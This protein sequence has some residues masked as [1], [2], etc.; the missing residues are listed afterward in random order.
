MRQVIGNKL[1]VAACNA[2]YTT[3]QRSNMNGATGSFGYLGEFETDNFDTVLAMSIYLG[4]AGYSDARL[5][6]MTYND[7]VYAVRVLTA[8]ETITPRT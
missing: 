7:M 1:G 3:E 6:T 4:I 8:P 5:A 2:P